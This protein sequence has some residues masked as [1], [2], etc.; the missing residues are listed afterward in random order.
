MSNN[1]INKLN[2]YTLGALIA[3][4]ERTVSFYAELININAYDQPGVE[5]GKKAAAIVLETQKQLKN[6]LNAKNKISFKEIITKLE[7]TNPE[8]IFFILRQMCFEN[9]LFTVDGDWSKPET[10]TFIKN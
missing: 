1:T 3:L 9:D 6:I 8:T 10:L 4:F 7:K 2:S 5:A